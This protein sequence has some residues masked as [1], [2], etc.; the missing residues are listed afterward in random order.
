VVRVDL[1]VS[2]GAARSEI[3][4]RYGTGWKVRVA[5]AAEDG[6][7]NAELVRLL[8]TIFDVPERSV[9]I[10]FGRNSRTKIVEVEGVD[11]ADVERRL[12]AAS[13]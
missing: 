10:V 9:S 11:P 6:R 1:R 12:G 8:A 4:G 13:R 2:P 3:V 5:A 7:A